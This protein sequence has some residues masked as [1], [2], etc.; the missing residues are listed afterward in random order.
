MYDVNGAKMILSCWWKCIYNVVLIFASAVH[1]V[2]MNVLHVSDKLEN[3]QKIDIANFYSPTG[4]IRV[5][6]WRNLTASAGTLNNNY[7]IAKPYAIF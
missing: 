3:F 6:N 1:A 2:L 7:K 4:G 5:Y